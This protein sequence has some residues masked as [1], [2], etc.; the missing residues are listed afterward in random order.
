MLDTDV[1]ALRDDS[2]A[3]L[4][5]DNNSDGSGVDVEDASSATMV[6]FVWHTLMDG[7]V[8]YD[9]HNISDLV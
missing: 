6:V 8:N 5:V 9:I 2:L 1:D 3:N 7:T 4:L